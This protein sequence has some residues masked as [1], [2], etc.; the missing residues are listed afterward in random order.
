VHDSFSL[1]GSWGVTALAYLAA[2]TASELELE[3]VLIAAY[4]G[5]HCSFHLP[6]SFDSYQTRAIRAAMT[7]LACPAAVTPNRQELEATRTVLAY[8]AAV[9]VIRQELE[10]AMTVLAYPAAVTVIIQELS[11]PP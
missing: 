1:P 11:G 10:A 3:A 8:P 9:T 5:S 7:V 4:R 2:G 6:S